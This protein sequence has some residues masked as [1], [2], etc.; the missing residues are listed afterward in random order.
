MG[1][2][3]VRSPAHLGSQT[4][5]RGALVSAVALVLLGALE[6]SAAGGVTAAAA[7]A[8]ASLRLA[9]K[10]KQGQPTEIAWVEGKLD[11]VLA[12]ARDRNVPLVVFAC[13]ADEPQNEEFR[14]NLAANA[15]LARGLADAISMYASNGEPPPGATLTKHKE[16]MDEV[17]NRWVAEETPDGAWPLPEVLIVGPDGIV[18]ERLGS[19]STVADSE[20]LTAVEDANKK[21]G[22]GVDDVTVTRLV[23]LRD[24][25]RAALM[26]GDLLAEWHAWREI[27]AVTPAG[28]F[29]AEAT[30]ALPVADVA[31]VKRLQASIVD[32]NETNLPARYAALRDVMRYARGTPMER[33]AAQLVATLEKDK[34]FKG[35]LPGLRLEEEARDILFDANALLAKGDGA[36]AGKAFKKLA[37]K[38]YAET[39]AAVRARIEYPE[40]MQ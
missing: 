24:A 12:R 1:T 26:R 17:Y 15:S 39:E 19:G 27:L 29:A 37:A 13:I 3:A 30:A 2:S 32:A 40:R 8:G 10:D 5:S 21:L 11:P 38:K 4:W 25:G 22:G 34:R 14:L 28:P 23:A 6:R 35:L 16:L 20:V 18:L 33:T 7:R 9:Q 36:G 31:L